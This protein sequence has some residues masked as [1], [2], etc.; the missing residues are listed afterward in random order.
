[1]VLVL[2]DPTRT[3]RTHP[4]VNACLVDPDDVD[5]LAQVLYPRSDDKHAINHIL[6]IMGTAKG[7]MAFARS[8]AHDDDITSA[9]HCVTTTQK[10]TVIFRSRHETY[11]VAVFAADKDIPDAVIKD[12]VRAAWDAATLL[13]GAEPWSEAASEWWR[14]W[15]ARVHESGLNRGGLP[16]WISGGDLGDTETLDFAEA[17]NEVAD[18]LATLQD[19]TARSTGCDAISCYAI[20]LQPNSTTVRFGARLGQTPPS[21]AHPALNHYLID[22]I[23]SAQPPIRAVP[24]GRDR[25]R[26]ASP[27][28]STHHASKWTTLSLGAA[29]IPFFPSGSRQTPHPPPATTPKAKGNSIAS[30]L[31]FGMSNI[32]SPDQ[33]PSIDVTSNDKFDPRTTTLNVPVLDEALETPE[34]M[35][36]HW[37][38]QPVFLFSPTEV[39]SPQSDDAESSERGLRKCAMAYTIHSLLLVAVILDAHDQSPEDLEAQLN[40]HTETQADAQSALS[41]LARAFEI[42]VVRPKK[43]FAVSLDQN[44]P[45]PH[46]IRHS[47]GY[48]DRLISHWTAHEIVCPVSRKEYTSASTTARPRREITV[49]NLGLSARQ[50]LISIDGAREVFARTANDVWVAARRV[51]DEAM[52]RNARVWA[53]DEA[54][55]VVSAKET[56][57]VDVEYQLRRILETAQD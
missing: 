23:Q 40:T 8:V 16:A 21:A 20:A 1:M 38:V 55:M 10:R 28:K 11:L 50:T 9:F 37:Q 24:T 31:G 34:P 13:F 22:L 35:R 39:L 5:E 51:P 29:S 17:S 26:S 45:A 25:T 36:T 19:E 46:Y 56:S 41:G 54:Y 27:D 32:P 30:W 3:A 48:Y 42:P 6:G 57:I 44:A 18:Q 53:A 47:H 43:S 33:P 49:D 7:V 52:N 2:F 14:R 12:A 4:P 15:E